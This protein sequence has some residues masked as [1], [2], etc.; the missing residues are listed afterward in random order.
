MSE[1][2][3]AQPRGTHVHLDLLGGLA[4]DMFLAAAL[5]AGVV[6]VAEL[7]TVLREIGLGRGIRLVVEKVMRGAMMGTHLCFEGW[8]PEAEADHRHLSTI[9]EMLDQSGLAPAVRERS[10]QMFITLGVAE[11]AIHGVPLERVHFHEVGAVDSLLDFVGA[12]YV[13]EKLRA[14]WSIGD[15]PAGTGTMMSEHGLIPVP[16]PATAR[17]LQGFR[18]AYRDVNME[19]VTPTGAAILCALSPEQGTQVRGVLRHSGF[20]AGTRDVKSVANMVRL[21]VFDTLGQPE[22]F[23]SG[24]ERDEVVRLSA[25]IDDMTPEHLAAA[26]AVLFDAGA[27]DVVREAVWM[28]KGRQGTRLVVL[29]PLEA[30]DALVEA[31]MR[32][33]SS[34]G[35]RTERLG[36]YKLLRRHEEVATP[37]GPVRVKLGFA[38]QQLLQASPEYE[39]C[40]LRA[41]EAGTSVREVHDAALQRFRR[42]EP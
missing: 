29:G 17:L 28:K 42:G 40:L 31:V 15:V 18:L 4:G 41:R 11:G 13:I 32:H 34:F 8:D 14:T 6:E 5:D 21:M 33:T 1:T 7:E 30:E 19:F 12:A 22:G 2:R 3:N 38:G 39:D 20:G 26:E 10:K 27:L 23:A 36:R 37:F 16:A 9:L 35:V 25:E 24:L